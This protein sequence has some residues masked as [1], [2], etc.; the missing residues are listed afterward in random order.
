MRRS[1]FLSVLLFGLIAAAPSLRSQPAP[2][3]SRVPA[4]AALVVHLQ[5]GALYASPAMK[6]IRDLITRAGPGAMQVFEERFPFGPGQLDRITGIMTVPNP[7]SGNT[8]PSFALIITT[9]ADINPTGLAEKMGI[10]AIPVQ[11]AGFPSWVEERGAMALALPQ[12]RMILYGNTD[13]VNSMTLAPQNGTIPTAIH[14]FGKF[15]FALHAAM[16]ALSRH[17][18]PVLAPRLK[19]LAN[20]ATI[21]ATVMLDQQAKIDLRMNYKSENDAVRAEEELRG[22]ARQGLAELEKPRRHLLEMLAKPEKPRPSSFADLPEALGGLVGLGVLNQA[23]EILKDPPLKREGRHL[24]AEI[25]TPVGIPPVLL[26]S[27]LFGTSMSLPG[28]AE[29]RASAES[30]QGENNLKQIGLAMYGFHERVGYIPTD[31][32]DQTGKPLLSWRV[33]ILPYIGQNALYQQ[34]KLDEPWNSAQNVKLAKSVIKVFQAPHQKEAVDGQGNGLT[35]YMVFT[36]KGSLFHAGNKPRFVQIADGTSNTLLC[37]ESKSPAIWTKPQDIPFSD[38]KDAVSLDSVLGLG[39]T[40]FH[41]LFCDGSVH[42]I[43]MTVDRQTMKLLIMP[44]DGKPVQLP[45][46]PP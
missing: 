43:K 34:F 29:A 12:P 33:A 17:V 20:A 6:E 16:N 1:R 44:S 32:T 11:G 35:H 39:Q 15:H 21:R 36:G 30:A 42:W 24:T 3:L 14:D 45:L 26:A 7:S 46:D 19:V 40:G 8:R 38:V 23:A 25:T 9:L 41:A 22:L 13:L 4:N 31:I 37:V 10:K 28:I 5:A 18:E 27:S 2:E